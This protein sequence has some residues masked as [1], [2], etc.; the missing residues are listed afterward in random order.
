MGFRDCAAAAAGSLHD[1]LAQRSRPAGQ[2]KV[3]AEAEAK[4]RGKVH[5]VL[6]RCP[7]IARG[8]GF[9]HP[10]FPAFQPGGAEQARADL[11]WRADEQASRRGNR[12]AGLLQSAEVKGGKRG[13]CPFSC[14][15]QGLSGNR[16]GIP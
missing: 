14:W 7:G 12:R 11:G 10:S 8:Q 1:C 2:G 16:L 6:A 9:Q 3:K 4:G 5:S 15:G 13:A